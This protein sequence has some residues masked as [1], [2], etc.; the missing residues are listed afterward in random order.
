MKIAVHRL[1]DTNPVDRFEL[2]PQ[3]MHLW[4][5]SGATRSL[6]HDDLVLITRREYRRLNIF[7]GI[8]LFILLGLLPGLVQAEPAGLPDDIGAG[9]F[10]LRPEQ[11]PMKP[12]LR[13][14]SEV[15]FDI[16][17]LVARTRIKQHFRNDSADWM[18]GVYVFPL[19][20]NAAVDRLRIHVGERII[21]GA[22]KERRVAKKIYRKAKAAGKRAALV[23]QERPNL[24]TTS[25]ANIPPHDTL[26]VEID[27]QQTLDYHDG[28]FSLRFPMTV[29][30]R[31]IPGQ[32]LA[33]SGKDLHVNGS[34]WATATDQVPDAG[35]ITPP[36]VKSPQMHNPVH[37]SASLGA[38]FPLA[39]LDSLYHDIRVDRRKDG[40]DIT[41]QK[42][43]VPMDRDFELVWEPALGAEP[44]AAF[45]KQ[46]VDGE[47]YG[48][49]MIMPPRA[50]PNMTAMQQALPREVMFIIDTSGSMAGV[51]MEQARQAL[52]MALN[53]LT[54]EDRFNL[55]EFNSV[56]R[57]LFTNAVIAD[58]ES[59]DLARQYVGNLT[60][61][62][63]TEMMPA[64]KAALQGRS[65]E[66]YVR[67]IVFI[68][69]GSVGNERALFKLIRDRLDNSRLFTVGIGSAP[70]SYF[71]RKAAQYGRGS[72]TFIGS[73]NEVAERMQGLFE[74]LQ[75]P[76]LTDLSLNW[77]GESTVDVWPKR[78]QDL[79]KDAPFMI[80]AK[81]EGDPSQVE[82]TGKILGRA[83][84]KKLS[85]QGGQPT[86]GVAALWARNKI[87]SL[88][89][90]EISEGKSEPLRK[91][92]VDVAL[93]H[94]LV[95]RYT[96]LVAVDPLMIRSSRD[97]LKKA[98]IA[99]NL[100]AGSRQTVDA[101]GYPRGA[102]PSRLHMLFGALALIM[103]GILLILVR[104]HEA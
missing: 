102:T 4:R 78:L 13:L 75:S 46:T 88:V 9:S 63:G 92:I 83:W 72:Y 10:F 39:R 30:P 26:V 85:L 33:T 11:G 55:I 32:A 103:A 25:V 60:A 3:D 20:D 31:Y 71:M 54:P 15:H 40:Y 2:H 94:R 52:Q 70:N 19:P 49:I 77:S 24:F 8:L 68:T 34:G 57:R 97:G 28:A 99:G 81:L 45:F 23:E 35:R 43:Q 90:R 84:H 22:I 37:I 101:Y 36:V 87:A 93:Q 66:G 98:A 79:Y 95:S 47:D 53:T 67:Q 51:S 6:R 76:V 62:G 18:E 82:L 100:P 74:R 73:Q 42:G 61:N 44:D 1:I 7:L 96:S 80:T 41:L 58:A 48:L 50:D 27:Y 12:A 104:R 69:D 65:L 86:P 5:S 89:D 59:V 29:T 38:G 17:G 91:Q 56:T 14:N 16:G 21:E 64:L